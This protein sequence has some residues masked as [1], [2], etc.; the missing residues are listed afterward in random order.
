MTLPMTRE[1]YGKL[2]HTVLGKAAGREA[3][4][5]GWDRWRRIWEGGYDAIMLHPPNSPPPAPQ[6]N[7]HFITAASGELRFIARATPT[8][9]AQLPALWLDAADFVRELGHNPRQRARAFV[10]NS[11]VDG[12]VVDPRIAPAMAGAIAWAHHL[13]QRN[14]YAQRNCGQPQI[15]AVA[16]GILLHRRILGAGTGA[17]IGHVDGD[18]LN[19]RRDNLR[20]GAVRRRENNDQVSH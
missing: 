9:V 15:Y 5:Q 12:H 3:C 2:Y 4:R 1:D 14:W 8:C 7:D 10:H 13:R 19:N 6:E 11:L 18:S 20:F 17:E 16:A